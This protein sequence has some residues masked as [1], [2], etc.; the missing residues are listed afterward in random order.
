MILSIIRVR[1]GFL[2]KVSEQNCWPKTTLG[3]EPVSSTTI[4]GGGGNC[5]HTFSGKNFFFCFFHSDFGWSRRCRHNHPPPSSSYIQKPP[6]IRVKSL[7]TIPKIS[8]SLPWVIIWETGLVH[9]ALSA[10]QTKQHN[11]NKR[12]IKQK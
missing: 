6:T 5:A 1:N 4:C 2:W 3:W 10:C 11:K 7:R 8:V 12:N 9:C